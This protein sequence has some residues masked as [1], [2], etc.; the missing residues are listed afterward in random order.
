ML[1]GTEGRA[2]LETM[3]TRGG[4]T[5]LDCGVRDGFGALGSL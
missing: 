4:Y 3:N 2:L 1:V 5:R